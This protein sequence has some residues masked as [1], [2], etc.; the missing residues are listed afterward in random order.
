MKLIMRDK[1]L[2]LAKY[3]KKIKCYD[4][5]DYLLTVSKTYSADDHE[6]DSESEYKMQHQPPDDGPLGYEI[7]KTDNFPKD[8]LQ[9]PEWYTGYPKEIFDFI[10]ILRAGSGKPNAKIRIYRAMP[11]KAGMSIHTGNWVTPSRAYA[12]MH[13]EGEDGWHIVAADVSLKDIRWAGDDLMEW[14]YWGLP[15]SD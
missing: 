9:H 4:E 12:E 15:I 7:G 11:S 10:D 13:A 6:L 14:G 1:I 8:I 2:K 5:L 3:L